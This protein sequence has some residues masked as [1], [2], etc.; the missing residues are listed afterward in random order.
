MGRPNRMI[1]AVTLA[2]SPSAVFAAE[3]EEIIVTATK[4]PVSQQHV[5]VAVTGITSDSLAKKGITE[6]TD[7]SGSAPNLVVSSPFGR[8]QPN[9]SIRGISVANEYNSNAASPIGLYVNEDYKQF[10]PTH[11]MQ[12]FDLD[13]IE[14]IRGPQGTLFGRNTTGGAISV[15]T[16]RPEP[17]ATG[18]ITGFVSGRYGSFDRKS[19]QGAVE[20]SLVENVLAVRLAGTWNEGDGYIENKT[21]SEIPSFL[22]NLS[23]VNPALAP[24][25]GT[26]VPVQSV[27]N[28]DYAGVE[29][30]AVRLTVAFEPS[31]T[32][33]A[34]LVYLKGE[35]DATAVTPIPHMFADFDGNPATPPTDNFGYNR[36]QFGLGYL[37]N[38]AND[39]G[40]FTTDVDDV[41]LSMNYEISDF[42]TITSN[43]GY[44]QGEYGVQNDCDGMPYS[45]CYQNLTSEFDQLNQDLRISWEGERARFIAGVYYGEDSIT[46]TDDKKF[47]APLNELA[48][49]AAVPAFNAPV[50]DYI[51]EAF[52]TGGVSGF[53]F[54]PGSLAAVAAGT[55]SL[56]DA[57]NQTA[58]GFFVD[59]GYTQD[60]ESQAIYFEGS[61]DLTSNLTATFGIRYTEDDF[62]LSGLYSY[63][64]D[65]NTDTPQINTIPY[66]N[67]YQAGITLGELEGSSDEFTGRAILNYMFE[68]D[69]MAFVSLSRGYRSGTFNGAANFAVS[70]ATFVDPEFIDNFELGIKSRV[71]DGSMQLNATLFY[72]DYQDQQ[73]QEVI[74]ATTF[75]RNASGTLQGLELEFEWQPLGNLYVSAGVGYTDSEYDGGQYFASNT[76]PGN[77]DCSTGPSSSSFAGNCIDIEGNQFPFAP[78]LNANLFVEWVALS[79]SK[80]DLALGFT[81]RYQS[82]V[83]F[84]SFNDDKTSQLPGSYLSQDGYTIFDARLSYTSYA[85]TIAL[86]GKNLADKEYNSYGI[87][88]GGSF[89]Y[90]YHIPGEPRTFGIDL[91]YNF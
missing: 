22:S 3:L 35:N 85:Y 78:E 15:T 79:T 55:L 9:F 91:R 66:A 62:S 61:Y 77:V 57:V 50:E 11:G 45:A 13:R 6:T 26:T 5:P 14:V 29:D 20:T 10:R 12:L 48:A 87:D 24:F 27:H 37:E 47:F 74:G 76:N 56:S 69:V 60:R 39:A 21:P 70:Q 64:S 41:T 2:L 65:L 7:L 89:G 72:A 25:A 8:A 63:L 68:D 51:N 59:T 19:L 1:L 86:W 58:N 34:T 17:S 42:L 31:E 40:Y 4:R 67:P 16:V 44:L 38:A 30:Y 33:G 28:D 82:E 71:L 88:T 83:F 46:E 49:I 90:D 23:A 80:G 81:T 43:T 18:D 73:V 84:D 32:F 53:T 75:L 52:L 54:A 36:E